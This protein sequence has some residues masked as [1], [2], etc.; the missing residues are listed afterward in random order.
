MNQKGFTKILLFFSIIII[1]VGGVAYLA[2]TNN[3]IVVQEEDFNSGLV[4]LEKIFSN[5]DLITNLSYQTKLRPPEGLPFEVT[6]WI[7]KDKVK[8]VIKTPYTL[9]GEIKFIQ[10][11]EKTYSYFPETDEWKETSPY[12]SLIT[13]ITVLKEARNADDTKI[14]GEEVLNGEDTT[15]VEYTN[16]KDRAIKIWISNR[17]LVPVKIF[18]SGQKQEISEITDVSFEEIEDSIFEIK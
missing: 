17:D 15:L 3:P 9:T 8:T 7:K 6:T 14:T 11:G 13:I 12:T 5:M 4:T 18:E 16:S 1:V 2:F 10:I